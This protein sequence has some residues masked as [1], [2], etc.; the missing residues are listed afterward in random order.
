LGGAKVEFVSKNVPWTWSMDELLAWRFPPP[1]VPD[2]DALAAT[3]VDGGTERAAD[4]G[5]T[6]T[7]P[8]ETTIRAATNTA[9]I[10]PQDARRRGGRSANGFTRALEG[11]YG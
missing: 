5:A 6:S 10:G 7:A 8:A 4:D 11:A 2:A 9:R 3:G 1:V